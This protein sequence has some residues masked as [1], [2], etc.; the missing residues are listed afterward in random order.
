MWW[1][2][3]YSHGQEDSSSSSPSSSDE[4]TY[5]GIPSIFNWGTKFGLFGWGIGPSNKGSTSLW[6]S[7]EMLG[8]LIGSPFSSNGGPTLPYGRL[9]SS[10][11]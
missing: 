5:S 2:Y 6:E 10:F 9:T 1:L 4:V 7:N 3:D 8:G 11:S